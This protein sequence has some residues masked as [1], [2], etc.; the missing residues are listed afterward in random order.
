MKK[1]YKEL[2]N[3]IRFLSIDAVQKANSGHPGMP[4]GMA[5][6]ATV[7]F[8]DFL[9]FNPKNPSWINRDRF[10]LSAG[11]G[12]MLLYSL[13][14]LTGYKSVSLNDIKNFRQ[15]ESIC[16]GHPEYHPNTGIETT[17]GPLGQGISNAVGFAIS[18]EILKKQLGKKKIDHKTYV[19]AGDGCLMEGIS[20]EALS[21]AG[22]LKL[23]NLILL[24][25]NNSVSIDGPTNL[26]VSDN[27]EKRFKSYGW[28]YLKINGHDF[29]EISKALKKAQNSKKPIAISCKTTIGY[30]SPNKGGK[31]SSH[32]SPLG[33]E[34]IKLVRKK[35]KWE[36]EPFKIPAEL[37][38]EWRKIG[39]RT[40]QKAQKN[41]TI[42]SNSKN[43]KSLKKLI[44]KAKVEYFGN[45]KPIATRKSSEIFLNII[46]KFPNLIGGSADLAG[47]NNTKT[48]DHKI[49]KP[50]DFS[51]NYIHYGV[52]EHAMCGIMNGIAL[53]SGLIPYGGTFLIFSDYCKPSIRLAAMMKQQ[54]IYVFTH[55]SIGLGEDGPT[56]Q[57]IE[58]LT[59][60]RSIPN[61]NVFR[62]SDTI[63]TFE[64]WEL[65]LESKN[66]P[67]VISLTRQGV[68]P[69]RLENSLKNKSSLGAYEVLRTG[70]NI[71]VTILATGSETS[72]ANDVGH[73][74]ATDGIYSKIIS[75]PCQKIFDHQ[76]EEYK[77]KILGETK[78]VVSIEASET[79]Y[80][81]KY[82][83]ING[84]NFGINDFGKSAPYKKIYD[85][86]KLNSESIVKKIKEKL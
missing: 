14:Y 66:T 16:A 72:L 77:K 15:L 85:H 35:L 68:N 5:D 69:I 31:A 24:F 58:Q 49:I 76:N 48:K 42:F 57:P 8:K 52:R 86:F 70:D 20:H 33:D 19:L 59:S 73:K 64:C 28:N 3:C 61:L 71:S 11:H 50:G 18:E 9:K 23:K 53:H 32:G 67:S 75:M 25:D 54:V 36:Y 2:A 82:T 22:H 7:L 4:M 79:N 27:H 13:L 63:E 21:L 80:W 37:L 6:V 84:L 83:G 34:E 45:M 43:L 41:K 46:A 26:A 55:D 65:A 17:T 60:L 74:L 1:L 47:S 51:G 12:S 81:K 10:V 78:L 44:E 29:K 56:H 30:G 38:S 62:P 39:E 40:S